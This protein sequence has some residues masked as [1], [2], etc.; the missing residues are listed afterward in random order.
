MTY[1]GFLLRFLLIPIVILLG[2]LVWDRWRG[3][4]TAV[5][6]RAW[7]VS[8]AI[9][10]HILVALIYTTPWDNYLVATNVWWYDPAL[11]TGITLGWVPI[12]E[13]TF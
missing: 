8:W 3:R 6:L 2:L 7:P 12:E 13:Y 10:L 1:F 5:S 11:V 9:G 4:E